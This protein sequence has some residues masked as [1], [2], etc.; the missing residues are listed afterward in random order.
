MKAYLCVTIDC[1]CDKGPGWRLQKPLRFDGITQGIGERL[2]PLFRRMGAKPSYLLSP[3]VMADDQ[4]AALLSRLKNEAELGTHLHGE[5]IGP[6]AHI[7][8]VS[9]A[10]QGAYPRAVEAEKLRLLTDLFRDRFAHAP[11]SFRAG[12]FGI[13]RHSLRLLRDLGYWAD[14]SVTPH[15]NWAKIGA[16]DADFRQAPGQ[17]YWPVLD[18]PASAAPAPTGI[19]EIPVTIRPHPYFGRWLAPRWLR[20]TKMSAAALIR[21]AGE[22]IAAAAP[23]RPI[24]LNCIFHNV[25]IVPAASPYARDRAE[26]DAI[27][28]NLAGLLEWAAGEKIA[29]IG[30]AEA[31]EHFMEI[32]K[33][34][35][36]A[37]VLDR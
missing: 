27:L 35:D 22:E 6:D 10:V 23:N 37:I 25:E 28:A 11:R 30:L 14:S 5:F 4:C 13:G 9:D 3:E 7:P 36:T 17:P 21:L 19:V 16:K 33:C 18:R 32:A 15:M 8:A 26:A 1:E 2:Q 20:P 31:A 29:V 34:A 12:R 24:L